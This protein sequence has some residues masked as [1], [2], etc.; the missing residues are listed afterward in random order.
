V[1][2]GYTGEYEDELD[3]LTGGTG[4]EEVPEYSQ[5]QRG[6]L[7]NLLFSHYQAECTVSKGYTGE[8]EDEL[9]YMTGGMGKEEVPE[10]VRSREETILTFSFLPTRQS[11]QCP[12]ATQESMRMN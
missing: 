3:D 11:V 6:N 8:Y 12:R 1:S 9:D 10:I 4:E 7:T 2:K 5:E